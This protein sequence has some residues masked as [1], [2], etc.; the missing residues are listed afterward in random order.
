[1]KPV[2]ASLPPFAELRVSEALIST[3]DRSLAGELLL[4]ITQKANGG[5]GNIHDEL[6]SY[7]ADWPPSTTK[8]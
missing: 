3:D 2:L 1:M 7:Q 5:K 4:G 6:D 8:T